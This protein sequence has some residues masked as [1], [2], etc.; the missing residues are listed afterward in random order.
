[1]EIKVSEEAKKEI[2]KL[3]STPGIEIED[4]AKKVKLDYD[5]IM[6]FLSDEFLKHNLD[7]GRRVCCRF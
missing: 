6:N 7:Y 5:I 2:L 1:M 3:I 4:I